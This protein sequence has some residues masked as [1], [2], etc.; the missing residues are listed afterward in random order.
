MSD[1]WEDV[2]RKLE[3]EIVPYLSP[4][5]GTALSL[6]V[7]LASLTYRVLEA[8]GVS[9]KNQQLVEQLSERALIVSRMIEL[10]VAQCRDRDPAFTTFV[11][12]FRTTIE[13]VLSFVQKFEQQ[14]WIEKIVSSDEV[15]SQSADLW[16]RLDAL[17]ADYRGYL[18]KNYFFRGA[19]ERIEHPQM[20]DFWNFCM[21]N[22]FEAKWVHFWD[23]LLYEYPGLRQFL[24]GPLASHNKRKLQEKALGDQGS[25][26]ACDVRKVGPSEINNLF[27]PPNTP[28]EQ[29]ISSLLAGQKRSVASIVI[30]KATRTPKQVSRSW[31]S[32]ELVLPMVGKLRA[33]LASAPWSCHYV[34]FDCCISFVVWWYIYTQMYIRFGFQLKKDEKAGKEKRV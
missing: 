33:S 28:V 8:K 32:G 20:R 3:K 7:Q 27:Q 14:R 2:A 17:A 18:L 23:Q 29:I 31:T 4:S 21:K 19:S 15:K 5:A 9:K 1:T 6:M 11:S 25:R 24:S 30:A 34:I 12:T 26:S 10:S 16:R 22:A 13:D